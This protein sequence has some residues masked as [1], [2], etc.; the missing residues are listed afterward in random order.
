MRAPPYGGGLADPETRSEVLVR[1]GKLT[2][3]GLEIVRGYAN[4]PENYST[5]R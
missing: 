1:E 3:D 5:F 4:T 2:G